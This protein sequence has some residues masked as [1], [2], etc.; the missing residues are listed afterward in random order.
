ML[1]DPHRMSDDLSV[2][3]TVLDISRDGSRLAYGVRQ[4]G[5]DELE[6][7]VMDVATR[8]DLPAACQKPCT[9]V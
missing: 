7:R 2:S 3:V 1:I 8:R 9:P 6:V 4:G 5:A